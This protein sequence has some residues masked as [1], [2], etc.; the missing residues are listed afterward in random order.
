[1]YDEHFGF[2]DEMTEGGSDGTEP[3][4]WSDIRTERTAELPYLGNLI[5]TIFS[6]WNRCTAVVRYEIN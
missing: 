5:P 6:F 1:M 4:G 3:S 2:R